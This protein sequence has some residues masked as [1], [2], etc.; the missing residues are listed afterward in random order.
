MADAMDTDYQQQPDQAGSQTLE[1]TPGAPASAT[2]PPRRQRPPTGR[3]LV[4]NDDLVRQIA[5]SELSRPEA[6]LDLRIAEGQRELEPFDR[7]RDGWFAAGK[8]ACET[9]KCSHPPPCRDLEPEQ[10]EMLRLKRFLLGTYVRE[11]QALLTAADPAAASKQQGQ[12]IP[13]AAAAGKQLKRRGSPSVAASKQQE[14]EPRSSKAPR[15][16]C[17]KCGSHHR[18]PCFYKQC[19][20]CGAYHAKDA[21]CEPKAPTDDELRSWGAAIRNATSPQQGALLGRAF[22]LTYETP[23]SSSSGGKGKGKKR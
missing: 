16:L 2:A 5:W 19:G 21:S 20:E 13:S 9:C 14:D 7:Q 10:A 23:T 6:T 1:N 8:P 22:S 11:Q 18:P 12:V 3:Q 17:D 15:T 4:K